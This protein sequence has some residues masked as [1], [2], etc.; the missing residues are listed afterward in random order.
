MAAAWIAERLL[1]RG[2]E[3]EDRRTADVV[4]R[5]TGIAP[6]LAGWGNSAAQLRRA[7]RGD[8]VDFVIGHVDDVALVCLCDGN[9]VG[10]ELEEQRVG[11]GMGGAALERSGE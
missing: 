2:F 5:W 6:S 9:A 7:G 10:V 3:A 1:Q 4:R 8:E 11:V